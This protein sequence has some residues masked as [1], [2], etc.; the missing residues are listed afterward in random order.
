[1]QA[2]TTTISIHLFISFS[3]PTSSLNSVKSFY[4]SK[5]IKVSIPKNF[6]SIFT[7]EI[8]GNYYNPSMVMEIYFLEIA[9]KL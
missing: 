3:S 8:S 7:T 9:K 6:I 4:A 2:E 1:M 5:W